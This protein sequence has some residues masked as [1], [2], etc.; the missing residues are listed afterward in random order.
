MYQFM[1]RLISRPFRR[2]YNIIV[3][4][5]AEVFRGLNYYLHNDSIFSDHRN[6]LRIQCT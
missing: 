2:D 5:T 1:N 6:Q 4:T 3:I